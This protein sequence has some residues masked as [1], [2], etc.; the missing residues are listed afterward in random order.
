[1]NRH[2]RGRLYGDE[3]EGYNYDDEEDYDEDMEDG[4]GGVHGRRHTAAENNGCACCQL[5][6]KHSRYGNTSGAARLKEGQGGKLIF[7]SGATG[8]KNS[9]SPS[10]ACREESPT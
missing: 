4:Y 7:I 1:M 2:R 3:D 10:P 8:S 9:Q 6:G 5:M